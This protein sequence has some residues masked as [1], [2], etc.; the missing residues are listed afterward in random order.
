MPVRFRQP[1]NVRAAQ[2]RV[3]PELATPPLTETRQPREEGIFREGNRVTIEGDQFIK[4]DA[5][6][7]QYV[8]PDDEGFGKA[9]Q[10]GRAFQGRQ[11]GQEA[12][13]GRFRWRDQEFTTRTAEE[14]IQR[15]EDQWVYRDQ[16]GFMGEQPVTPDTEQGGLGPAMEDEVPGP[17]EA[18]N[19]ER[20]IIP[21][22]EYERP[23]TEISPSIDL[24]PDVSA[25]TDHIGQQGASPVPFR[26]MEGEPTASPEAGFRFRPP[27][28]GEQPQKH[29]TDPAREERVDPNFIPEGE[30]LQFSP[31]TVRGLTPMADQGVVPAGDDTVP[32]IEPGG[33]VED[34]H[35]GGHD[36][37]MQLTESYFD[38]PEGGIDAG[39]VDPNDPEFQTILQE[40]S[41]A[42]LKHGAG[43]ATLPASVVLGHRLFKRWPQLKAHLIR[44]A[45]RRGNA[46]H[47]LRFKDASPLARTPGWMQR[48]LY[49]GM[50]QAE[51]AI[52]RGARAGGRF[53]RRHPA[54]IGASLT[55]Y[56][57]E[58]GASSVP[59]GSPFEG[60]TAQEYYRDFMKGKE[61]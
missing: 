23:A 59:P 50:F 6:R 48:N 56:P 35:F 57:T 1:T 19:R 40:L 43:V 20:L 27:V 41:N 44:N 51:Q 58:A 18:R 32:A 49:P 33:E 55:F 39:E 4:D 52:G 10:R 22:E 21:D 36:H 34:F 24:T 13:E 15:G 29:I 38:Q 25:I 45:A 16:P 60:G 53:L 3:T 12:G 8:S 61:E 42:L 28:T 11:T 5:G 46:L 47:A 54:L 7:W 31:D 9:F 17:D 37:V 30:G 14:A 2:E 26:Q